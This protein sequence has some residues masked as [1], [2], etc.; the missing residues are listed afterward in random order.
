MRGF[1]SGEASSPNVCRII[2]KFIRS[3]RNWRT[4]RE[5]DKDKMS[6]KSFSDSFI[7]LQLPD[8]FVHGFVAAFFVVV[9]R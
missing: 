3:K 2:G 4:V 7:A 8:G 5:N 1:P 6:P 9:R